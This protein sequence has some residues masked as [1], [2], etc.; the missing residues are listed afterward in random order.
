MLGGSPNKSAAQVPSQVEQPS[1][2]I[3]VIENKQPELELPTSAASSETSRQNVPAIK[4]LFLCDGA[5]DSFINLVNQVKCETA[6]DY[7][8]LAV[9]SLMLETGLRT[10]VSSYPAMLFE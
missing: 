8:Y 7:L 10:K 5:T 9:H 3:E 4:P 2:K 1:K 6:S